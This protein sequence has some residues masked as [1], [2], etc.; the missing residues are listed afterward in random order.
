MIAYEGEITRFPKRICIGYVCLFPFDPSR[1]HVLGLGDMASKLASAIV[2]LSGRLG[3]QK[4][5]PHTR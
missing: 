5:K 4:A 1:Y 2:M 3:Q